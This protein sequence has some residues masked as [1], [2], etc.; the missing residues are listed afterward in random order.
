MQKVL[1]VVGK[2]GSG[3]NE[4]ANLLTNYKQIAFADP[5]KSLTSELFQIPL[6]Y[7]Y[8]ESLKDSLLETFDYNF[9]PRNLLCRVADVGFS[10]EP[11][12]LERVANTSISLES[13]KPYLEKLRKG[14]PIKKMSPY[15]FIKEVCKTVCQD[16]VHN[17]VVT[18]TR[19]TEEVLMTSSH[20]YGKASVNTAFIHR[21]NET[22]DPEYILKSLEDIKLYYTDYWIDNTQSLEWLKKQAEMHFGE[23]VTRV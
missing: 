16:T 10:S 17:F 3:K 21:G 2:S 6:N 11:I 12:I 9:T 4:F 15:I 8:E 1:L 20:L 23:S 13:A 5:L 19:F 7:F 22:T 14:V 18:D